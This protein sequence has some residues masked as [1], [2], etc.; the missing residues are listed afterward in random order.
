MIFFKL[1][2]PARADFGGTAFVVGVVVGI[3]AAEV[4][5]YNLDKKKNGENEQTEEVL[6]E[7]SGNEKKTEEEEFSKQDLRFGIGKRWVK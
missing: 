4:S 1:N 5:H 6:K 2:Q 3:V 7:E